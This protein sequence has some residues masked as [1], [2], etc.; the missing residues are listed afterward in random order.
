ML[1][2]SMHGKIRQLA[3]L[4]PIVT[5]AKAKEQ[6]VVFTNGCFDLLHPGHLHLLREA[7]KLGHLL[8]V[9]VNADSTVK[10]IKG[11][12]RPILPETERAELLAALETVDYVTVFSEPDPNDI[13]KELRPSVLVKG[14]DWTQDQVVG[15][16]IVERDGG[17]V[18]LIPL[19]PGYSTTKIIERIRR[20]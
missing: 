3:E 17:K 20:K 16:D 7:K 10:K 12:N 11:P 13:I 5:K 8:I 19:L 15:R 6:K 18:T 2:I 14:G 4:K 9:G 1:A